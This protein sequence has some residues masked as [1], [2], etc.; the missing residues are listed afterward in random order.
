MFPSLFSGRVRLRA[1]HAVLG[2]LA[3]VLDERICV[4]L[5]DGSVVPLGRGADPQFCLK[6]SG[7]GVISSLLR[8]PTLEN[9]VR[10]YAAGRLEVEGGDLIAFIEAARGAGRRERLRG[11]RKGW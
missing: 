11:L 1:A 5:W 2:H 3:E 4:R 9:C 6:I 7:P 10:H 8:R